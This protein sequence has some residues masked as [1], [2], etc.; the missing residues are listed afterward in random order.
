MRHSTTRIR[1]RSKQQS[2]DL[3]TWSYLFSDEWNRRKLYGNS[4]TYPI[5]ETKAQKTTLLWVLEGGINAAAIYISYRDYLY[6]NN[7]FMEIVSITIGLKQPKTS[8]EC[9]FKSQ[10]LKLNRHDQHLFHCLE[11]TP[12]FHQSLV[13][14]TGISNALPVFP[15]LLT[16]PLPHCTRNNSRIAYVMPTQIEPWIE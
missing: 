7:S 1:G 16:K 11:H 15:L 14:R 8:W 12:M 3:G 6:Q 10:V 9:T 4:F 13:Q 5:S 2:T